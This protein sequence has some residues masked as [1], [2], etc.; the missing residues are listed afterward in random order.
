MSKRWVAVAFYRSVGCTSTRSAGCAGVGMRAH[1]CVLW[2]RVSSCF[3]WV[4]VV[5][6]VVLFTILVLVP[7]RPEIRIFRNQ[8]NQM[9]F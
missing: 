3:T 5:F 7:Q 4:C 2:V 1:G 6:S 9:E 8:Q